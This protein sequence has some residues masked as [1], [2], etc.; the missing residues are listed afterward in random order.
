MFRLS[1]LYYYFNY[2]KFQEN[3][4]HSNLINNHVALDSRNELAALYYP[5]TTTHTHENGS[6]DGVGGVLCNYTH[7]R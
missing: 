4:F 5:D 2:R 3:V 6:W 7:V 1:R